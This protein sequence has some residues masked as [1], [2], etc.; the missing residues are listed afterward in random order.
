MAVDANQVSTSS[1]YYN[2]GPYRRKVNARN[3]EAQVWCVRGLIWGYAFNHGESEKC[4]QRALA[5]DDSCAFAYWGIAY[6]L[7]PNYNVPWDSMDEIEDTARRGREALEQAKAATHNALPVEKALVEALEHRFPAPNANEDRSLWNERY[8]DAMQ[9]V[10]DE[11]TDDIDVA[12]LYAD[13]LMNLTPWK[14]WDLPSGKPAPGARTL[15]AKLVLDRALARDGGMQHPG[16]LHLYIHLM[17]MSPTPEAALPAA[18]SLRG[19]VPESG[20]KYFE[21]TDPR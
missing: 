7:G 17:E 1:P 5:F 9:K 14:L 2:L 13:A 11:Y 20:R 12:A 6:A 19:I 16:L 8:A 15:D 18:D 3:E 21:I 10:Y 4:F